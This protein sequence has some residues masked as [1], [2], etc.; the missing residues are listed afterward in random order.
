MQKRF[1]PSTTT[2]TTYVVKFTNAIKDNGNAGDIVSTTFTYEGYSSYLRDAAS[3][4]IMQV[5]R[6]SGD[7]VAIVA[8]AI[9]T[10][11]Y[12]AGTVT[13]N[14]FLPTAVDNSGV[15][16]LSAEPVNKD[17]TPVRDQIL[18]IDDTTVTTTEDRE[19]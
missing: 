18:Q 6:T 10:I 7:S 15:I 17:I 16:K 9:G 19:V 3:N 12:A 2:S 14:S 4:N 8:D 11:D 13:L 1:T 5:V